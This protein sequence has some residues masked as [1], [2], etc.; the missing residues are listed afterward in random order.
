[1]V[2]GRE[3]RDLVE[4]RISELPPGYISKKT[5]RGKTQYYLQWRENG[6]IKSKYIRAENVE[7]I[8]KQIEERKKLQ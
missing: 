5:I 7:D 6:K 1:M 2:D 3:L 4:K 8:Q